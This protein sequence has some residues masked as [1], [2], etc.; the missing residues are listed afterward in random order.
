M[1]IGA[2]YHSNS[3]YPP[4][5]LVQFEA[6]YSPQIAPEAVSEHEYV[7][8]FLGGGGG[9]G[10]GGMPP[11][12]PRG[13]WIFISFLDL[14]LYNPPPPPPKPKYL[15]PPLI[16]AI[17]IILPPAREHPIVGL[18]YCQHLSR[19]VT[20]FSEFLCPVPWKFMV[21][22]GGHFTLQPMTINFPGLG[23]GGQGNSKGSEI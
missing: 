15:D 9:G 4:K 20:M 13:A 10:G 6:K 23:G 16:K 11:D 21:G 17:L 14:P 8:N 19:A 22:V 1:T 5:F 7:K 3:A 2:K 12:P 18:E